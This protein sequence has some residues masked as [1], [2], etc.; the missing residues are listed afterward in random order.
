MYCLVQ[1]KSAKQTMRNVNGQV[2]TGWPSQTYD[3]KPCGHMKSDKFHLFTL[4][5]PCSRPVKPC[6][7]EA[8]AH[9]D[10]ST[11]VSLDSFQLARA[12]HNQIIEVDQTGGHGKLIA[13]T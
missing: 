6:W 4:Y 7:I 3:I 10:K 2:A 1:M 11:I 5:Y 8:S 9:S 13:L 12:Y